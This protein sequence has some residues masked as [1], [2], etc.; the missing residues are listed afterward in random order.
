MQVNCI[1]CGKSYRRKI[2]TCKCNLE[3][4]TYCSRRCRKADKPEHDQFCRRRQCVQCGASNVK[5]WLCSCGLVRYCG[6]ECQRTHRKQHKPQC[7]S[8]MNQ[9]KFTP[10]EINTLR[11]QGYTTSYL[12]N[13]CNC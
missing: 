7:R 3:H 9:S 8:L 5:T 1:Y 12:I 2:V 10:T 6:K 4:I 11:I 13:L